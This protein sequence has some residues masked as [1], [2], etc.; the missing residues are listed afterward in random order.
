MQ[1]ISGLPFNSVLS[2]RV[3]DVKVEFVLTA[4]WKDNSLYQS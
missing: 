3:A 1:I 2:V 4:V